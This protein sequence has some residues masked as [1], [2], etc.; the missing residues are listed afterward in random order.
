MSPF[1]PHFEN[2]LWD[3]SPPDRLRLSGTDI[4]RNDFLSIIFGYINQALHDLYP[5]YILYGTM[6]SYL[7]AQDLSTRGAAREY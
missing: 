1:V 5:E 7:S 3:F 6:Y 2:S 4:H